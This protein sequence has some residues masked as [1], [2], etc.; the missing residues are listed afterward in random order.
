MFKNSKPKLTTLYKK[1]NIEKDKNVAKIFDHIH[2]EYAEE[3]L[4]SNNS[5][6][7]AYYNNPFEGSGL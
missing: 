5:A 2:T 3:I 1:W 6:L 7:L 4:N